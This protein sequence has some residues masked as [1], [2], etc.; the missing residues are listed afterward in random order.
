MPELPEVK[1]MTDEIERKFKGTILKNIK[2]ESGKYDKHNTPIGYNEILKMLPL[3][4]KEIGTKG[5][6][7]W[8]ELES[9]NYVWITLGLT[10]ELMLEDDKYTR[11]VFETNK[12]KFYLRDMR[13]FGTVKF[14]FTKEEMIK[15]LSQLGLEPI[16][17][18]FSYPMF[19]QTLGKKRNLN[20]M[21]AIVL[22]EQDVFA[23]IG[24]YL[25]AE[26]LYDANIYPMKKTG[27]LTE[28]ELKRLYKSMKKVVKT[29]YAIQQRDGLHQYP[30]K[31]YGRE[32]TDKGE[33]VHKKKLNERTIWFV[34]GR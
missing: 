7:I 24:N 32:M 30:F 19:I 5:K 27:E 16:D 9:E 29:S 31:I 20:K 26:I 17:K 8:I 2:I 25:R 23:G 14:I 15:K 3:K 18:D 28:D 12:G 34:E 10:G 6:L 4:I 22:M 13:N 33:K 1:I 11:V 21:I